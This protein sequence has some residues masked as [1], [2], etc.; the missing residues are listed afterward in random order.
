VHGEVLTADVLLLHSCDN[1]GWPIGCSNPK[2]LRK[3]TV[4]DNATDM[5]DRQRHG[6]PGTVVRAIR[7]LLEQGKTEL[8]IAEQYGLTRETVSAIKTR[9]AYKHVSG[10]DDGDDTSGDRC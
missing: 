3:G 4:A 2:H 6:L 9:R 5:T 8:F 1:G 10:D 7:R